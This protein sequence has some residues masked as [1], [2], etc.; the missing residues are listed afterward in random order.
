MVI[1][2]ITEVAACGGSGYKRW[3]LEQSPEREEPG[4]AGLEEPGAKES[5]RSGC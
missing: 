4:A 5:G 2:I 3:V 1:A